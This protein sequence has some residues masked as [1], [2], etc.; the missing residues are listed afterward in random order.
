MF[1]YLIVYSIKYKIKIVE[2]YHLV[3]ESK[4]QKEKHKYS[5]HCLSLKNI[6]KIINVKD[7]A[8]KRRI[9]YGFLEKRNTDHL[10]DFYQ[11]K[12]FFLIS[13]KPLTKVGKTLDDA[14]LDKA[15]LNQKYNFETLYFY[16]V[17]NKND[18]SDYIGSIDLL[19]FRI[20]TCFYCFK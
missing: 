17:K 15:L 20:F 6:D 11:T 13:S 7:Q 16:D 10:I 14:I 12:W 1:V 8:I 3:F 4:E 9:C 2:K 19:Y 5:K 18:A